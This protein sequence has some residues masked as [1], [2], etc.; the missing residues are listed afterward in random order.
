MSQQGGK[1][2][3]EGLGVTPRLSSK[4]C[5]LN[6]QVGLPWCQHL[7]VYWACWLS[8]FAEQHHT[9][10]SHT[11]AAVATLRQLLGVR[12]VMACA[13]ARVAV[14]TPRRLH[15]SMSSVSTSVDVRGWQGIRGA[16]GP[17]QIAAIPT[18]PAEVRKWRS[19]GG[20][21]AVGKSRL[22]STLRLAARLDT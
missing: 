16:T 18:D 5:L 22:Q 13:C 19:W 20:A 21:R 11:A 3:D 2:F 17:M 6:L 14:T 4:S 8:L 15:R 1:H 10:H 9:T 12:G 7:P